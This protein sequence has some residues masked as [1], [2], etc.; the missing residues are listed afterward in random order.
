MEATRRRGKNCPL[1]MKH[2][3]CQKPKLQVGSPRYF[4]LPLAKGGGAW[5]LSVRTEE[6]LS[7]DIFPLSP[8]TLGDE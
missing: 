4:T 6:S 3:E 2:P 7:E 5:R 8:L 1:M